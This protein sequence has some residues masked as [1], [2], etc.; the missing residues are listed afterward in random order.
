MPTRV[1]D[2]FLPYSRGKVGYIRRPVANVPRRDYSPRTDQNQPLRLSD[3]LQPKTYISRSQT[4]PIKPETPTPK[5]PLVATHTPELPAQTKIRQM[6]VQKRLIYILPA[7]VFLL[8][9][10]VG[11]VASRANRQQASQV[12]AQ[13][14][15]RAGKIEI[16][17]KQVVGFRLPVRLKIPKLKVDAP[18]DYMSLT[19]QGDMDTPK[20]P[21]TAGWY[22]HGPRPGEPGSSV[23]DGHFGYKD[24]IPAVF[25]NLHTLQKGDKVY[26]EDEAGTTITFVV[27]ELRTYGPNDDATDVFR[28]SDGKAHLNLITCQG[29]WNV[30]QQSYSTRLVA[31]TDKETP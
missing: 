21:D 10:A 3:V 11:V 22:Q 7:T 4:T 27:R 6:L 20:G 25:D 18:L 8:G 23:I 19:P 24:G 9:G 31:F 13:H 29:T 2:N 12:Q 16:P 26:I 5:T 14:S 17:A 15:A 1:I 28:S 30:A